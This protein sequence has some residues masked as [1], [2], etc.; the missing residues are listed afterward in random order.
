MT[1]YVNGVSRFNGDKWD[2]FSVKNGLCSDDTIT[3]AADKKGG[4]WVSAY[5]G[6]SYYDGKQWSS[7]SNVSPEEPA[8]GGPNPMKDCQYMT[9][10]DAELSAVDVIFV[11]SLGN[12]WFST[13]SRGITRFYGKEWQTFTEKDG[14]AK[15]G[16][17]TLFE[18]KDGIVWFDS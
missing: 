14:L 8:I 17:Y 4:V 13:R 5:W 2:S 16:I 12:V 9:L 15:G 1:F 7:Y 6:V 3:L 10:V 18:D 11:D